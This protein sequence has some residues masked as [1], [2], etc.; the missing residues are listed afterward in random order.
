MPI[1]TFKEALELNLKKFA[2]YA[3]SLMAAMYVVKSVDAVI[4]DYADRRW[5]IW[6]T[7]LVLV[8]F[9]IGMISMITYIDPNDIA[10]G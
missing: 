5:V 9:A 1:Y 3:F 4:Q 8:T 7:T 2:I 10:V 6:V